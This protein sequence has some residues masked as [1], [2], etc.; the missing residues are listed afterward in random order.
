MTS[1]KC[2]CGKGHA[3]KQDGLCK[4]CREYTVRRE[5]AKKAGVRSRGDGLTLEQYYKINPEH[6]E[7][8]E[9]FKKLWGMT[10]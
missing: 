4:F 7:A 5:Q 10:S 2:G 6:L 9:L 8:N 3:A 1:I